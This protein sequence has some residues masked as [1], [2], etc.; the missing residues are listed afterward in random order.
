MNNKKY[1]DAAKLKAKL[2]REA[3]RNR[4]LAEQIINFNTIRTVDGTLIKV[5]P[6]DL[7]MISSR[8]WTVLNKRGYR[9]VY[10]AGK[11]NT[12]LHRELMGLL[13]GDKRVVDH[14]DGDTT[15]YTRQNLRICTIAENLRNSKAKKDCF[16]KYKGV[17][18]VGIEHYH[19]IRA[20]V[21]LD[22]KARKILNTDTEVISVQWS[23]TPYS[24]STW[25]V[26]ALCYDYLAKL[27]YGEYSK[28]NASLFPEDFKGPVASKFRKEAE[29]KCIKILERK[30]G[31]KIEDIVRDFN[32][33]RIA[34]VPVK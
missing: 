6:E 34:E 18:L 13:P 29:D 19:A 15:N 30:S 7:P 33:L 22:E 11:G 28:I 21:S 32:D 4:L 1:T 14:I 20:Q 9:Y 26:A 27:V 12:A 16:V 25:R 17:A 5:S 2:N 23:E 8:L 31:R 10:E 24:V 3:K